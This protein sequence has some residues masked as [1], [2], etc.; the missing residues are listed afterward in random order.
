VTTHRPPKVRVRPRDPD[1]L[2][3]VG[4]YG[5][6]PQFTMIGWTRA[7]VAKQ[8]GE[9]KD[10]GGGPEY[11]LLPAGDCEPMQDLRAILESRRN[12]A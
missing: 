3:V 12:G 10:T 1:D 7:R 5:A 2:I 11:F 8:K 4:V 6:A 9:R